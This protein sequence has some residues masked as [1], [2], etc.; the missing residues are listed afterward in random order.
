MSTNRHFT[1]IERQRSRVPNLTVIVVVFMVVL[2]GLMMLHQVSR[3]KN[4]VSPIEV[5]LG[6][7]QGPSGEIRAFNQD[8]VTVYMP[9]DATTKA[10]TI[11]ISLASPDQ[12]LVADDTGWVRPQVVNVE[13]RNPDGTPLPDI[14]FS[15][16]LEIC[17]ELTAEQWREFRAQTDAYQVQYF[18]SQADPPGWEVLPQ[19]TY[20]ARRQLCGQT[21]H[22]SLFS[23]ATKLEVPMTGPTSPSLTTTLV[24]TRTPVQP[25]PTRQRRRDGASSESDLLP[26]PVSPTATPVPPTNPPPTQ[27]PT[28]Q[29]TQAPTQLPTQQ[30]TDVP[31]Q[32]PTSPPT[33]TDP[34][35]VEPTAT[36]EPAPLDLSPLLPSLPSP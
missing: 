29:P 11:S 15:A 26:A 9:P 35:V 7:P 2:A 6:T 22:L 31:T 27:A 5:L 1:H 3:S 10:G 36:E 8:P 28:Q 20:P 33:P 30:P 12:A 13:F 16:P 23:L 34:P 25:D 21:T 24:P 32:P 19:N 4:I 17:F 14:A 18:A